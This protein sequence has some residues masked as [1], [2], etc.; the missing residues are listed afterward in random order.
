[1]MKIT[2]IRPILLRDSYEE[3]ERWFFPGGGSTGW[4][5]ALIEIQTE[6][7]LT[8]LGESIAGSTAP[9]A[10]LGMVNQMQALLI[11]AEALDRDGLTAKIRKAGVYW[12]TSGIGAGVLSALDIAL[13]DI[14][15]KAAGVP[16]YEL[17][18]GATRSSIP[19]YVSGGF[20]QPP[21]SFDAEMEKWVNAGFRSVKIRAFGSASEVI[22]I[23]ERARSV[24]GDEIELMVDLAANF[25]P[26]PYDVSAALEVALG[27]ERL[28]IAFL[29]EPLPSDDV[30]GYATL[31]RASPVQIAG[32][33]SVSCR[34]QFELL[35]QARAL[36][37][38][39]P[40]PT[41]C[42]GISAVRDIAKKALKHSVRMAPHAWGSG[43]SLMASLHLS[44]AIGSLEICEYCGVANRL[45][46][47]L[48][49]TPLQMVEGRVE[50]PREAGLGVRLTSEM[51]NRY[52][53]TDTTFAP[54][55]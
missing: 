36:H 52:G 46:T 54:T 23:I 44:A 20:S 45:Q 47:G 28:N 2:G 30:Q 18:G 34:E 22:A 3:S 27:I 17:L 21:A 35:F 19:I 40:D 4:N 9:A 43:I 42:G 41:H 32:G 5:A 55:Y 50:L 37:L 6:T 12:A 33:E 51:E 7:G 39:Q 29:E 10:F 31:V 38:A 53:Q 48:M 11:G 15:G 13:W 8:G 24:L 1:M 16:V 26:K 14:A 25:L 49:E